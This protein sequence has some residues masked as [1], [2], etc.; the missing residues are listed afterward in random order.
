[1]GNVESFRKIEPDRRVVPEGGR[2]GTPVKNAAA[3]TAGRVRYVTRIGHNVRVGA[4][5]SAG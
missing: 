5:S 3:G 2:I 1:M 4:C